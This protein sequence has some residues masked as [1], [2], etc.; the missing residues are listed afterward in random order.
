M[1]H[2]RMNKLTRR[3]GSV[4]KTRDLLASGD[5]QAMQA[6]RDDADCPVCEVWNAGQKV[7]TID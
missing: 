3:G 7:G 6:A 2:Y 1:K 4:V 5:K